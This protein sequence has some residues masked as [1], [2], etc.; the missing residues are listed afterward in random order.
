M[1][2]QLNNLLKVLNLLSILFVVVGCNYSLDSAED[3]K[4]KVDSISIWIQRSKERIPLKTKRSLLLKAYNANELQQNDSIKNRVLLKI[5]FEVINLQD[6]VLF[7]N[8][9]TEALEISAKIKDTFG[10]ADAHWNFAAYYIEKEIMEKAFNHYQQAYLNFLIIKYDYFTAKMLYNMSYAQSRV[11]DY[12]GSEISTFQAIKIFKKLEKNFNLYK[13]YNHLGVIYFELEEFE[14]ALNY[15]TKSIEYL[16]KDDLKGTQREGVFNNIGLIY[17]KKNKY[18]KAIEHFEIALI[19]KELRSDNINLYS[20]LIDNLAYTKFLKEDTLNVLQEMK[21]SLKIRD[22][23]GNK[24]G[25]VIGKLHIAEY[26]AYR[27]DTSNAI[28]FAKEANKTALEIHNNRDILASLKLL[29]KIDKHNAAEYLDNYIQ[30]EDSLKI[31]ERKL[32]NKFTRIRFETDEYIEETEKLSEQN[33]IIL[34]SGAAVILILSML[35]YIRI[36]RAKNMELVLEKEQQKANEEIYSLLIKQQTKLEEGQLKERQRI[37]EDL[38]DGVLSRIFGTRMGLDLLDIEGDKETKDMQKGYIVE[39][40]DIEKDIRNIS[41]ELKDELHTGNLNYIHI[42]EE[43]L[44]SQSVISGFT[45][46]ITNDP[47][48][49]WKIIDETIKIN[50][51][52]IIQE[53]IQNI[54]KHAKAKKVDLEFSMKNKELKIIIRDNG[55]GFDQSKK[56]NGIGLRNIQSRIQKINGKLVIN[57]NKNNGTTLTFFIPL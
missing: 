40:Q 32:R 18:D 55:I 10:I 29:S 43:L 49:S 54:N 6:S 47:S 26:L 46:K 48:I 7:L 50:C 21:N 52:R 45:Y 27:S 33:V 38:H 56:K 24:S 34:V 2:S 12:T 37:S 14:Q 39:L 4:N 28:L 31:Q 15:Y 11:K 9:N 35:Y 19:N 5:A 23:L 16:N 53:A 22:S 42:L 30:L 20:R 1:K 36:Q 13:C 17:R 3:N 8:M 51:Y 41:H 44:K 25:Q 57:S